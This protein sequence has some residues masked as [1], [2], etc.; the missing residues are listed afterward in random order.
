[1]ALFVL[2]CGSVVASDF[3]NRAPDKPIVT[4]TPPPVDPEVVRQGGDT[5]LDAVMVTIPVVDLTGTTAG[6]TDDYDEVCPY[7]DSTS[8]DVVYVFEASGDL[9][10]DID[11]FGS[12]YDTKIYVYDENYALVA[13]NDDFYPDYVSKI[14]EM[15][16]VSG[17]Q[18]FVVID[19]Y[20]GAFGDYV[21][22]IEGYD[23]PWPCTMECP[24]GGQLEGEPPL[25][26]DYVDD[27]NG[28]CNTDQDDPPFQVG[29]WSMFCGRSGWYL[30]GGSSFR[31]TDWFL[32][33]IP[34]WEGVL[35]I[36]GD[37]E[38]PMWMFELGPMDCGSVGVVQQSAIG[39]C[40]EGALTIIGTPGVPVWFWVGPQEFASPD[41]SDVFEFDY[42]LIH[43]GVIDAVETQSWTHVKSLFN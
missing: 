1:M 16:V 35:E 33:E 4:I 36:W 32:L 2:L 18:Y 12:A 20:G 22:N 23:P 17:V 42:V 30:N 31:D 26:I 34:S 38:Y 7:Q 10:V 13:C 24:T 14:E 41:G 5:I 43:N 27:W 39:P 37:A 28:G 9:L 6:Y 29:F 15:P 40:L 3:G 8:P 21:L 25:V 19:G 11:M